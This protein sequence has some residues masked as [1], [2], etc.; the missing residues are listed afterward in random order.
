MPTRLFKRPNE[1]DTQR[2]VYQ[3]ENGELE[4]SGRYALKSKTNHRAVSIESDVNDKTQQDLRKLSTHR[5]LVPTTTMFRLYVNTLD[6]NVKAK[7]SIIDSENELVI[8]NESFETSFI[9]F[10]T[11]QQENTME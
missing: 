2:T 10:G 3:Q 9:E 5:F 6:S 4:W 1:P 7:Y 8:Q 11:L